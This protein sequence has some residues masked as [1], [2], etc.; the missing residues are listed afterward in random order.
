MSDAILSRSS[1]EGHEKKE[2]REKKEKKE[3]KQKDSRRSTP[4][5]TP[6]PKRTSEKGIESERI[7]VVGKIAQEFADEVDA[8]RV[9]S[10]LSFKNYFLL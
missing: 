7:A 10:K 8:H 4:N 3:K 1:S 6:E 2:K 5:A 9:R